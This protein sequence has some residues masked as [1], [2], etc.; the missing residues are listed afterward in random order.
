MFQDMCLDATTATYLK[1]RSSIQ[2][3]D[4]LSGLSLFYIYVL[5]KGGTQNAIDSVHF[6]DR[7]RRICAQS[8]AIAWRRPF[9]SKNTKSV[10]VETMRFIH[11]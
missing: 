3:I 2:K 8:K 9:Q 6:M 10:I 1:R 5:R 4:F 11:S 7:I